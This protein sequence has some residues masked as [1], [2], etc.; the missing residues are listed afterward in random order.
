MFA[1]HHRFGIQKRKVGN[2]QL[3]KTLK[4]QNAAPT[5]S[6]LPEKS[7]NIFRQKDEH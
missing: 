2:S 5:L 3:V 6:N 1:N 7:K 4:F